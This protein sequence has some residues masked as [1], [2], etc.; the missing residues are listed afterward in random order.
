[1][2]KI[3]KQVTVLETPRIFWA[4]ILTY[5]PSFPGKHASLST[6]GEAFRLGAYA[7]QDMYSPKER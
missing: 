7:T 6:P 1:M 5:G 4:E 3:K 2:F